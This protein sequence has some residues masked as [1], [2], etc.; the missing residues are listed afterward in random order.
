MSRPAGGLTKLERLLPALEQLVGGKLAL[1]LWRAEGAAVRLVTG[2]P[3][4]W[5]PSLGAS[6]GRLDTPDGPAWFAPMPAPGQSR[7]GPTLWLELRSARE[8]DRESRESLVEAVACLAEAEREAG[9][10][11]AEL[12]DRYEEIDLVYTISEILGHTIRLDEAARRILQEV[13][14]VVGARRASLF[15]LDLDRHVLRL[16]ASKGMVAQDV[17]PIEL[18]D[19][20]SVTAR[21]FREMRIQSNDPAEPEPAAARGQTGRSYRGRAFLAVP[22]MYG[23]PGD[24]ARPIGVINLTDRHGPDLFSAGDRKL[25]AA[26]ANQVGAAIENARLVAR[27]LGQQR[28][29]RE[30]ELAHDLQLKLLPSPSVLGDKADLAARCRPAD[31]VG[32][33]F[34]NLLR[35]HGDR[36]GIMIGDVSNHG[37]GAALIMALAMAASGIHAESSA[38]PAQVLGSL[39]QS[40]AAEL[41]RTEMYL[42]LFYAVVDPVEGVCSYANAGH[43]HAFLVRG[44]TGEA[45]RLEATRTPLGLGPA[46]PAADRKEPWKRREDVLCLFTDGI[47]DAVGES[48]Q[49]FG[50]DRVLAHLRALRTHRA[51]EILEAIFADLAAF[52]GGAPPSD[53]RTLLIAKV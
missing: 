7:N 24:Q 44:A 33:D 23:A 51:Q 22:V 20:V 53:D 26:I 8:L 4:A 19:P 3:A 10:V 35:L 52:T 13:A 31:S 50:E 15:V 14:T 11:A 16:V 28:V 46:R 32:G 37:F 29:R 12:S 39:E 45:Q 9:Q 42:S 6:E 49:R 17:D 1:R 2:T 34:Y 21:A 43:P 36:V 38:A 48:G 41:A 5:T 25:V 47:V 18:D 27:D 30:L 40:L